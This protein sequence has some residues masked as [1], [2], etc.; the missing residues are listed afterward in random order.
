MGVVG[1][2]VQKQVVHDDAFHR[3]ESGG[4]MRG[5]GVR[6]QDVF[7][8][9]IERLEHSIDRPVEHVGDAQARLRI[10]GDAPIRFEKRARGRI[11]D[12]A[13]AGQFVWKA[14]HVTGALNI[15]LT[16]QRVHPNAAPPDISRRHGKIGNRHHGRAALAVLGNAEPIIDR[17]VATR[18]KEPGGGA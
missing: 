14:A 5:V 4:H 11:A 10:D 9:T 3:G 18:C 16:A 1:G 13:I 8:L 12:M 17:A 15:V 2:F 6:L 7:T